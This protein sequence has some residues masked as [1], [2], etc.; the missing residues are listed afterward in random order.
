MPS[1]ELNYSVYPTQLLTSKEEID[2]YVVKSQMAK[3]QA[4]VLYLAM[5]TPA[6]PHLV[7]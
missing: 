1:Q 2:G 5:L 3:G 7:T 4:V 6:M